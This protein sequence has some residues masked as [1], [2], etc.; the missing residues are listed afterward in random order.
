MTRRQDPYPL[1]VGRPRTGSRRGPRV[2]A[3][4]RL[5]GFLPRTTG[6]IVCV[7]GGFHATGA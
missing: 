3:R 5:S 1:V 4:E 7:D 6:E 2:L